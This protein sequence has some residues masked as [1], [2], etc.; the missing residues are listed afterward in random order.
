MLLLAATLLFFPH[1]E[2]TRAS[3][4]T[5]TLFSDANGN[6]Y[7]VSAAQSTQYLSKLDPDGNLIY[8]VTPN[9]GNVYTTAAAVDAAGN[10]YA[11]LTAF[12]AAGG[13]ASGYLA[14]IDPTGNIVYTFSL[15]VSYPG[16]VAAGPD[17][18][19]YLT[20]SAFPNQLQTTAGVWITTTQA[21][22]NKPNA[23]V[24]KL[25]PAT[26]QM[27]Y[28]TFLDNSSANSP[29]VIAAG[30][31]IAADADGSVYIAGSTN[32][33]GFPT[34]SGAVQNQCTCAGIT[35]A[36]AFSL[37]LAPDGSRPVYST[38][39]PGG[40]TPTNVAIGANGSAQLTI[41]TASSSSNGRVIPSAITT[42]QLT[43]T[44]NGIS[45]FT[46][47][48]L[49]SLI[50]PQSSAFF[51][52]VPDGANILVTGQAAPADL[53]VSEGALANGANFAAV[54]RASDGTLL[55]ATRLPSGAAG[56]GVAPDGAGG[57]ILA[58]ISQWTR[59]IPAAEP[60]PAIFGLSNVAAPVVSP[61]VA[62]GELVS[63]YGTGLGPEQGVSA[64]YDSSGRIPTNLAGTEVYFNGVRAPILYAASGQLNIVAPFELSAD[65]V[66]VTV[67]INGVSSN[68][69]NLP[70]TPAD[71]RIFQVLDPTSLNYG[72][73]IAVNQDG[74]LNSQQNPAQRGSVVTVFLNGA[75][76]LTPAP[77][78][79][80]RAPADL[81]TVLPVSVQVSDGLLGGWAS[82]EVLYAGSM[83]EEVA[84]KVQV[85]FVMPA[86]AHEFGQGV[87]QVTVGAFRA[88]FNIWTPWP[89]P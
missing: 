80:A 87:F 72:F 1:Y 12:P 60:Q 44:G 77:A 52:A 83:P 19:V 57:F 34:T 38:F 85:N 76:L 11:A 61:G 22:P 28:A 13:T 49:G 54:I 88:A 56:L 31:A 33:G 79:G 81:K 2:I 78:D 16:A 3:D 36:G 68:T 14:K 32:D 9:V 74:A 70:Q 18:S 62:P 27:I 15:P 45:N 64:A 10:V 26:Q 82:C 30:S 89:A 48:S 7:V 35:G 50:N 55:Y 84:G 59:L 5:V 86:E 4:S 24:I 43:P 17:G 39:L 66:N 47:T 25:N 58:G 41:A 40:D 67:K 20:G 21:E 75:G 69:A 65:T 37:K 53:P 29:A 73:A 8:R 51:A 46:S 23:Y 6:A 63:I 71:P 42:L